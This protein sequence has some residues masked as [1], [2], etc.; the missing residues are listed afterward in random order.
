MRPKSIITSIV[1]V[2]VLLLTACPK[3]DKTDLK[4]RAAN[5]VADIPAVVRILVRDVSGA[6]MA[7]IEAGCKGFK[8][9]YDNPT[10]SVWSKAVEGWR[11]I[12]P[13]LLS[14]RKDRLDQ[15]VAVV[16]LLLG[17]VSVPQAVAGSTGGSVDIKP[18]VNF[19]KA[20]VEKLEQLV[21]Q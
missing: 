18:V 21:R 13:V 14:F 8:L 11:A 15:I 12:E 5:A 10:A 17:Q 20:D 9:F 1:L 6:T 7:V 3:V 4:L 19:H 16:D 2:F